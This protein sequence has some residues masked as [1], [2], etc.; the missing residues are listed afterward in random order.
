M[1]WESTEDGEMG[2]MVTFDSPDERRYEGGAFVVGD[3]E[4]PIF[5]TNDAKEQDAETEAEIRRLD[6]L[7]VGGAGTDVVAIGLGK[8]PC[9][10]RD[11]GVRMRLAWVDA[12]GHR[13]L[14][15]YVPSNPEGFV[16]EMQEVCE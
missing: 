16:D 11:D 1:A 10:Q 12:A 14:Q 5:Y 7:P 2:A 15:E 8:V 6:E 9:D 13:H 4:L 3:L